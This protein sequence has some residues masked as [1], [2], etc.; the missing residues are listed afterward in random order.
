LPLGAAPDIMCSRYSNGAWQR[1]TASVPKELAL[2][3][4]LDGQEL[5]T[6]LCTPTK[7]PY[8]VLGYLYSEGIIG[9]RDDVA[10]MRVCEEESLAEV[11]LTNPGYVPPVRRTLGTGCGGGISFNP[12]LKSVDS[13][14]VVT[15]EQVLFLMKQ[16]NARADLYRYS[17][18]VHSSALG[19]P[20]GLLAV[21]EDIGRHNT[22]DKIL[23]DCLMNEMSTEG[24]LLLTTGR[25]SS[26]MLSKASR[27]GTPIIV[28]RSSPTDRS[29]S[30]A[31]ELGITLIG[32][33]RGSR[34]SVYSHEERLQGVPSQWPPSQ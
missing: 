6:L 16:L 9:S 19:S 15:P 32:Y 11:R 24:R 21:A 25:I 34:L 33:A 22:L 7:L 14:V 2:T 8:L 17:G 31:G 26:E 27:M 1:T 4:Y 3:I 29:V 23:G 30:L 10:L 28:S 13:A 18:G 20:D 12:N 5:I